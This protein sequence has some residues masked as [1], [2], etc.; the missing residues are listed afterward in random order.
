MIRTIIQAAM[1]VTFTLTAASTAQAADKIKIG[2][3]TTLS[4][5]LAVIGT[6]IQDGF[7]LGIKHSGGKLGGLSV[8]LLIAD[9]QLNPETGR[10]TA[11]RFIQSEKVDVMTGVVGSN[12]LLPILPRILRNDT[13]YISANSGPADYAGAKCNKNFFSIAYQNEDISQ[14]MGIYAMSQDFNR[15]ALITP[16]YP[17]GREI[18]HGFKTKYNGKIVDEIYTKLGQTD[19]ASELSTLRNAK[20]DAIFF[21]LPG[22]MGVNFI[23]QFA[24]SGMAGKVTLLAPG[25]SSD[26]DTINAVGEQMVG[27]LN[28]SQWAADLDND[29]NKKFV[30]DY[31]KDYGRIPTL[32][33]AQGYDVARL[34]DSAIRTVGGNL[35]NKDALRAAIHKA[36]FQSVRG[37]FRFNNNNYPIQNIYIREVVKN[38][39]GQLMNKLVGKTLEDHSD[40]FAAE[41]SMG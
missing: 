36:E 37:K 6:E 25:P 7:N 32:Y 2:L 1:A 40:R 8:E 16:N 4:G 19:F 20:P 11:E 29:A 39:K 33:A 31:E 27:L 10:Q 38:K 21:F 5:P 18:I 34:L 26:I 3:M 41:C 13:I 35:E 30:A 9:D 12:V 22:G 23:K 15:V 24:A 17:G 14:A 28:T